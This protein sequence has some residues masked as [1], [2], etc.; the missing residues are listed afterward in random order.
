MFSRRPATNCSFALVM[1]HSTTVVTSHSTLFR[2]RLF[3]FPVPL[4]WTTPRQSKRR[5]WWKHKIVI[6]WIISH[7]GTRESTTF[8]KGLWYHQEGPMI[9]KVYYIAFQSSRA[10]SFVLVRP[11]SQFYFAF[12]LQHE[13]ERRVSPQVKSGVGAAYKGR[14]LF[15][16]SK[17]K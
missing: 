10:S 9:V 7:A 3:I 1:A 5:T 16:Q 2:F 12:A 17:R 6:Y 13:S 8:F 4:V 15:R 14:H 11:H